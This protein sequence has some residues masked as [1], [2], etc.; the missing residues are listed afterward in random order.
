MAHLPK[1]QGVIPLPPFSAF[2]ASNIPAV[3]DNTMSYY[4]ELCALLKYLNDQVTPALNSNAEA[5]TILSNYVEHYFDNLD[6]QEEINNKLDEMVESGE[7]QRILNTPATTDNIGGVIIGDGLDVAANGKIDVKAGDDITVDENGVSVTPYT[8]YLDVTTNKVTYTSG[9]TNTTVNYSIIPAQY[10]PKIVMSNPLN[11]NTQRRASEIDYLYKPTIMSNLSPW[12]TDTNVTYGP[13]IVNNVVKVENNLSD[14]TGWNRPII[15]IDDNGMLHNIN[16]NT[17]AS[18]VNMKYACRAWQCLYNDG[19]TNPNLGATIEP[20]T[21]LAQDY[22][23]NYLIGTCGG[24]SATDTGMTLQNIISFVRT[25]LNFSARLIYNLDGGGSSNLLYH[26]IRQNDTV[27]GEDRACPTW[28]VWSSNT[29]KDNGEFRSQSINNIALIDGETGEYG[30]VF[31][32]SD[33]VK[34][35]SSVTFG[36]QSA[37][38]ITAH[39]QCTINFAFTASANLS[40]Y[41]EIIDKLP[42]PLTGGNV[43]IMIENTGTHTLYSTYLSNSVNYTGYSRLRNIQ[44]LPAGDYQVNITYVATLQY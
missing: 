26:G 22:D 12:N 3:Y 11:A 23:G 33:V 16:G 29:A 34:P 19:E 36:P 5:I 17:A 4:E 25:E 38:M 41:T 10:T 39:R 43:Y 9:T 30:V 1:G 14:G 32:G 35:S 28:L 15:G 40:A 2:L 7:L 20:R 21:F 42:Q 13:L 44:V 37:G 27:A 6:V 31:T 18:S 8:N 24:R